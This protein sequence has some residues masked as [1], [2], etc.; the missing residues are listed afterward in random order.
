MGKAI[1]NYTTKVLSAKTV[2][3]IQA[4]LAEEGA[5]Q[6]L[7]DYDNGS[8]SSLSFKLDTP[9][10]LMAFH[11]DPNVKGVL[12][13]LKSQKISP[14]YQTEEHA[15]RVAWR[16]V[17]DLTFAQLA[18]VRAGVAAIDKVFLADAQMPNGQTVY[19]NF[20]KDAGK[21]LLGP[22]T[23]QRQRSRS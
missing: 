11:M 10:G 19:E 17:K 20:R 16:I 8:V 23:R 6:I 21:F 5:K 3:E 13:S 1:D 2:G 22:V 18:T 14:A 9:N 7:T 4:R 12:A 15:A